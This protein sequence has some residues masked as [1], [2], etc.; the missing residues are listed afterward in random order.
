MRWGCGGT[1][2]GR[3]AR[4]GVRTTRARGPRT[5]RAYTRPRWPTAPPTPRSSSACRS[6]A[7]SSSA[8]ATAAVTGPRALVLVNPIAT[9]PRGAATRLTVGYHHLAAALPERVGTALLRSPVVTRIASGAMATTPDRAL[10][11]WIHAEHGRYF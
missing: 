2:E 4:A 5:W 3:S 10:R 9:T 8:A 7:T 11:R 1:V 6:A